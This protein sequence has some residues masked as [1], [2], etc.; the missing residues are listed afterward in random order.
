[1]TGEDQGARAHVL[2]LD[3]LGGGHE[4]LRRAAAR[5]LGE[6]DPPAATELLALVMRLSVER[7][8]PAV[9]VLPAFLRA[10]EED[11]DLI[12]HAATLRSVATLSQRDEV[13]FVFAE[14]EP[15][16]EYTLEAAVRADA[17][18][19]SAPLGVLKSRAR[20]TRNPD[21]LARLAVA[22][23]PAVIREVLRNA[24]LTE[25][26]VVRIAT[27]RPARPEPLAEIWRSARWSTLPAVRKAL[28]F[29]PFLAPEVAVKIV[30]T[31][32]PADLLELSKEPGVHPS[33]RE[34]AARLSGAALPR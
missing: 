6:L 28:V 31:L 19:F 32:G 4:V 30:P 29:N 10:L 7:W 21:E 3:A 24:R 25:A 1:M 22:S 2:R 20:L 34:L 16:G 11:L 33:V 8:E 23:H 12:P 9:R 18:L 26:L 14:G 15:V 17:R 13:A 5:L 27:R